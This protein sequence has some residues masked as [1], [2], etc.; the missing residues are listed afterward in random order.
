MK[1]IFVAIVATFLA[2]LAVSE[3]FAWNKNIRG[4]DREDS[5]GGRGGYHH[6]HED[7]EDCGDDD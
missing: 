7:K 5:Q 4:T 1:R 2:M 3:V 6:Q